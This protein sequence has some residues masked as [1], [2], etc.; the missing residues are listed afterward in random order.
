M[1]GYFGTS[2]QIA[3]Q[4][5]AEDMYRWTTSTPGACNNAR[6][7][8]SDEPDRLGIETIR[9]LL[10]EDGI[11]GFRLIRKTD[12]DR[13]QREMS[14][15]NA[16]LDTWDVFVGDAERITR[17]TGEILSSALP[18]GY[19]EM[20]PLDGTTGPRTRR[21]QELVA[22]SGIAP[23]SAGFLN[24]QFGEVVN[25]G[26][27][28]GDGSLAACA[29]AYLPHNAHSLHHR[30]AWGGLV[31]VAEDHRGKGLGTIVNA[32]MARHALTDLSATH[33][34]ELVSASNTASRKMV[35]KSGLAMSDNLISGLASQSEARF[36]R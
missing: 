23:F 28:D 7:L 20:Q 34:Y 10:L 25:V 6:M 18:D 32:L 15:A 21:F 9:K 17:A 4:Q 2:K 19:R 36:T 11:F 22:S 16:R 33:L 35:E 3:L 1:T 26:L 24:G 5:R 13:L 14:A 27:E 8:G 31:A 30:W 12:L 29:H